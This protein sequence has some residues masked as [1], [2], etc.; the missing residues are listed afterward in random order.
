MASWGVAIG[1]GVSAALIDVNALAFCKEESGFDM[2][3]SV[4]C[5][6]TLYH[7][8]NTTGALLWFLLG[9]IIITVLVLSDPARF[10]ETDAPKESVEDGKPIPAEKTTSNPEEHNTDKEVVEEFDDFIV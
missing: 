6:D 5:N 4:L 9:I 2:E 1:Q 8:M 10:Q 7:T 3:D